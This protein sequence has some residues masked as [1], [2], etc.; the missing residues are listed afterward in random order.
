MTP[1]PNAID[2]LGLETIRAVLCGDR[3]VR[4]RT[5]AEVTWR[6]SGDPDMKNVRVLTGYPAVFNQTYTLYESDSFVITEEVDPAFFDDVLEESGVDFLGDDVVVALVEGVALAKHG[7]VAGEDPHVGLA[8]VA[9]GVPLDV[10]VA[11]VA[12]A[13][14]STKKGPE[15]VRA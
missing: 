8:R 9:G 13:A 7:R 3:R 10:R 15:G 4:D 11:A 6:A 12:D 2:A 5:H 1:K 14:L